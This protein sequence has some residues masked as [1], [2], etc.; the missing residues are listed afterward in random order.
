[1]AVLT[2]S[3][4]SKT[5]SGRSLVRSPTSDE[6]DAPRVVRQPDGSFLADARQSR[7]RDRSNGPGRVG[8]VA[9]DVDTLGGYIATQIGRVPLRSSCGPGGFEISARRSP[10]CQTQDL[11][12]PGCG[13]APQT[14]FRRRAQQPLGRGP[15][16]RLTSPSTRCVGETLATIRHQNPA[17]RETLASL[18]ITLAW[19]WRRALIAF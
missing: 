15:P 13:G 11:P 3:F 18:A 17:H 1:M 8:E 5:L 12:Q 10:P 16:A 6:D 2:A 7:G 9:N 14:A 4:R 19:G